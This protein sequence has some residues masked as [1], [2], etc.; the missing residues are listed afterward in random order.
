MAEATHPSVPAVR[1]LNLVCLALITHGSVYPWSFAWPARGIAGEWEALLANVSLWS[2]LGDVVSNVVLFVPLGAL[3]WL[4]LRTCVPR[5]ASRVAVLMTS[6]VLFA[7]SLQLLQFFVPTRVPQLSDVAWNAL[8]LALGM[9]AAPLLGR[10]GKRISSA[11]HEM[12]TRMILVSFWLVAEWWPLVPT[13]DWQH[14][15]DALKPMLVDPRW[16]ALSFSEAALTIL[17][18]ARLLRGVRHATPWVVLLALAA[19]VGKLFIVGQIVSLGRATGFVAG[20]LLA[21]ALERVDAA[22]SAR[23]LFA[24][25][26]VWLCV[27]GLRPFQLGEAPNAVHW[28][29]FTGVLEGSL[30]ANTLALMQMAFWV[31]VAM[32]TAAELGARLAPLAVAVALL[33]L[34]LEGIQIFLPGRSADTTVVVVPCLWWLTLSAQGTAV[35]GVALSRP[36]PRR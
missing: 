9:A 26:V 3:A 33:L 6:G 12:P 30:S 17:A 24:A 13:V 29:P 5:A 35:P 32:L 22:R 25:V 11:H 20:L 2:G 34:L 18:V 8:G 36:S 27:D 21:A 10:L 15:K 19:L 23:L 14:V 1:V 31:G 16:S 7:F 28:L 4:D